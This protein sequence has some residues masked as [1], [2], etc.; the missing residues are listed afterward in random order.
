MNHKIFLGTEMEHNKRE[1]SVQHHV[2]LRS[3]GPEHRGTQKAST[4]HKHVSPGIHDI[5]VVT[6]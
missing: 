4:I 1:E 3:I 5:H 6:Q 2:Q